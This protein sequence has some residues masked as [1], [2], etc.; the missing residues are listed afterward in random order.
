MFSSAVYIV[1]CVSKNFFVYDD[2]RYDE[3]IKSKKKVWSAREEKDGLILF[4]LFF[5]LVIDLYPR[6]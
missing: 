1:L 4:L 6:P 3:F 2:E 5:S